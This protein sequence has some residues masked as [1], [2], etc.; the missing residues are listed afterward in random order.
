MSA[1]ASYIE[2]QFNWPGDSTSC[3][4]QSGTREKQE[5]VN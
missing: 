3:C 1:C 4:E 5:R 2:H